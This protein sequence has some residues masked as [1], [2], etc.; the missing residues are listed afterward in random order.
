MMNANAFLVKLQRT[1]GPN[2]M[3]VSEVNN[4]IRCTYLPDRM[5]VWLNKA[6]TQLHREDGPA[7]ETPAMRFWALYGKWHREDGPAIEYD[8]SG[9]YQWWLNGN[10]IK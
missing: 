8:I 7:V 3:V 4:L 9:T 5:H 2:N 6:R 1:M 10:Q